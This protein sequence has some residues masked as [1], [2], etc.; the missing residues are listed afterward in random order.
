MENRSEI[1]TDY[2]TGRLGRDEEEKLFES[3]SY[4]A[5]LREEFRN[6][7]EIDRA[8][9]ATA[10]SFSPPVN[11]TDAIF[12][13][14]EKS[15]VVG[16]ASPSGW[17]IGFNWL[18]GIISAA[19]GAIIASTIIYFAYDFGGTQ[20]L[21][22]GKVAKS[23]QLASIPNR[24][25]SSPERAN[26]I[27]NRDGSIGKTGRDK[28]FG[29]VPNP[30]NLSPEQSIVDEIQT[31]ALYATR[32]ISQSP[33]FLHGNGGQIL[34]RAEP[35]GIE[36]PDLSDYELNENGKLY[37]ISAE[38]RG[39]LTKSIPEQTINPE[40]FNPLNNFSAAVYWRSSD[41]FHIGAE[42]RQETFFLRY[43]GT[44][45]NGYRIKYEQTPNITTFGLSARYF[46]A[47]LRLNDWKP[48]AQ[49]SLGSSRYGSS[50][51]P[52]LG[53]AYDLAPRWAMTLSG[54]WSAFFFTH[55]SSNF[56]ANKLNLNYGI[57]FKF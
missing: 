34:N 19:V 12:S 46:P 13:A 6:A 52:G 44:D 22:S 9:R 4:D 30:T 16:T 27:V 47:R 17:P 26:S 14:I 41:E 35:R 54:E 56:R 48:F 20:R 38:F 21:E 24:R 8:M 32:T 23:T 45:A 49:L 1:I 3:F 11:V 55:Q 42:A 40:K 33:A 10:K 51:R 5:G 15:P 25:N 7:L 50:V 2:L 37:W 36:R 39:S 29:P 28:S 57:N 31:S 18:G 43:E 53:C